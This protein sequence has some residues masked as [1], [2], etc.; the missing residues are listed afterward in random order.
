V[1]LTTL[2]GRR[3]LPRAFLSSSCRDTLHD[4]LTKRNGNLRHVSI[5]LPR[6]LYERLAA[7]ADQE[8]RNVSQQIRVA[9][10]EYLDR[11]ERAA[12]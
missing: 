1:P 8:H 11:H 5:T 9:V 2:I 12:A 6:P 7:E 4:S 10:A 3:S